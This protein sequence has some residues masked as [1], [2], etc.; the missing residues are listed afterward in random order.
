MVKH[1][2]AYPWSSY[3][4]NAGVSIYTLEYIR[5]VTNKAWVMGDE[6]FSAKIAEQINRRTA[7]RSTGGDRRSKHVN[8]NRV[9][10]GV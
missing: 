1:P 8:R 4:G 9:I 2:A 7:K 6:Y 3:R 10:N 5:E